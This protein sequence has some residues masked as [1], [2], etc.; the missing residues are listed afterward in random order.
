M[1][2]QLDHTPF[3]GQV[4]VQDLDPPGW[5]QRLAQRPDHLLTGRLL[6]RGRDLLQ[7]PAIDVTDLGMDQ[8]GLEE[9]PGEQPE[10]A[11]AVQV[12]GHITAA[13]LEVGIDRRAGGDLVEVL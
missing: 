3:R 2:G 7:R 1:A 9:P 10:P 4:A 11:G 8:A 12:G 6:G 5:L 13:W